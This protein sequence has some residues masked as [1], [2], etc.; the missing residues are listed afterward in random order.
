LLPYA[1]SCSKQHLS[2]FGPQARKLEVDPLDAEPR[3]PRITGEEP[4]RHPLRVAVISNPASGRNK[5]HGL[6]AAIHALLRDHPAVPH[7]EES[8]FAGIAEATHAAIAREPEIVVVNGGDGTVQTVLTNLMRSRI[9][10]LPLLAVLPG[11]TTN[12]TARNVGYGTRPLD[13][14]GT[15]LTASAAGRLAG[16]VERRALVR[17]DL[18]DGPEYAMMFGAGAVYHGIVFA[19]SQLATHGMRGQLGAGVALATFLARVFTGRAGTMFPPLAADVH[20]DGVALPPMSYFGMLVST[21]DRQFLGLSPYWG[22]GP[23][24]LR[25]SA[26]RD[27]PQH[28][29]RAILPAVRG[30]QSRWLQPEYGYR[31]QNVDEVALTFDGGFTLDGELFEPGAGARRLLLTARQAA[32]FLRAPAPGVVSGHGGPG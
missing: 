12:T 1:I 14:L 3:P 26:M 28:L 22:V 19:R 2:S 25:F 24:P 9:D 8:T 21:M 18:A 27:R 5:R 15:L 11:G 6:L 29:G 20:L 4:G 32:Y 7:F 31:S 23:G 13:A 17:A 16:R 30:R 10:R